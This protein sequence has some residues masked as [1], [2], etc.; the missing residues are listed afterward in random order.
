MRDDVKK[1][2]EKRFGRKREKSEKSKEEWSK[3]VK[4]IG[5]GENGEA[6]EERRKPERAS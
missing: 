4:V 3:R 1:A 6:E 2:E 5:G